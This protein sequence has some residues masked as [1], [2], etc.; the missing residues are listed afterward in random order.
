MNFLFAK[1]LRGDKDGDMK[2]YGK[3]L[4]TTLPLV[5]V[6]LWV[7]VETTYF[8]SRTALV[9]LGETW[10]D[11]RL[12]E[13]MVIVSSQEQ[14][15]RD[16]GLADIPASITK[17]QMDAVTSIADIGVG[18]L[19]YMIVVTRQG[20]MVSHPDPA[21]VHTRVHDAGWF[22]NLSNGVPRLKMT[23][24]GEPVLARAAYFE[25]WEWYVLAVDPMQEIYGV[26]DR[27]RPVLYA[28][29]VFVALIISLAL[30]LLTRRLTRPLKEL[31]QGADRIGKGD[32]D[33]RIPVH[34]RDEFGHLAREFNQMAGRL[35]ETLTALKHSEQHF[36]ALIENASDMIWVLDGHGYFKYVSPSTRR[37]LGYDPE[38]LMG[39]DSFE[40]HHPEDRQAARNRFKRRVQDTLPQPDPTA[41]QRYRHRDGTYLV[42]E[43]ITQSMVNHPAVRGVIVNARDIT[44]RK[45]AEQALKRSHQELENRVAERTRNLTLL[46]QALNNEILVRKQKEQ[47]LKKANQAKSEFL[48]NMS[49]EIRTPLNAIIGFSEVLSAMA[50]DSQQQNYL[51]AVITSGKHLLDLINDLL[52]LS[53]IEAGK[54]DIQTTPVSLSALFQEI[55]HLFRVK[56]ANKELDFVIHMDDQM[57]DF[58][59]LD[60]M[61]LRQVLTNLV[62]NA[63][64]FTEHGRIRLSAT[65]RDSAAKDTVDLEIQVQ[66]TGIGI[67]GDKLQLIFESFEQGHTDITRKY[68]GTG[69]GL[70]ICRQLV[71][72][73][74]GCIDVD[75]RSSSGSTF[76]IVLPGVA[77]S[78]NKRREPK[79]A[80]AKGPDE[81]RTAGQPALSESLIQ[82]AVAKHP[83]LPPLLR[84]TIEP[85]LPGAQ[86]GVI[87]SD[88]RAIADHFIALGRRFDL[89]GFTRFGQA[90][91]E[92]VQAFDL[93]KIAPSLARLSILLKEMPGK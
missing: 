39:T 67:A 43:S 38:S 6:S 91:A 26:A 64:K 76:T 70:T 78:R 36:R 52:D 5:I 33:T 54:I 7:I 37:I 8:F 1:H 29:G 77:V 72:L 45:K 62:A 23:L 50:S 14:M 49:H 68:G 46:N 44:E 85:L 41:E 3:I 19:G 35:Q 57:P 87:M 20:R 89:P 4:L 11:T 2:T 90:L 48:A 56:L 15:L 28:M 79:T 12:S 31:V 21:M 69:L 18:K 60:E 73:M 25:P 93:E 59:M 84:E 86:E 9:D 58:L 47:E 61:R 75:S 74:K 88:A 55:H 16:Y 32:L 42:L 40:K 10:L 53:R 71:A 82:E 30:M 24:T 92:D 63:V 13:A 65:I 17:A 80:E 81:S 66:D 27:M 83:G 34:S 22:E 51:Q